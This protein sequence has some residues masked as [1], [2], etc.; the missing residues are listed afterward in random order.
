MAS[1]GNLDWAPVDHRARQPVRVGDLV[2]AEA[3]GMP[4]YTVVAVEPGRAWVATRPAAP[5]R[6]MPL[7]AFRWRGAAA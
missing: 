5:A 4:V 1:L 2:S 7:D 3:G 6:A